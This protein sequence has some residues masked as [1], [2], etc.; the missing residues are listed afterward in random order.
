MGDGFLGRLSRA[1]TRSATPK[2]RPE[3]EDDQAEGDG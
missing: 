3:K 1:A 2:N